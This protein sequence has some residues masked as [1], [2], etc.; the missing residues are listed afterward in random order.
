MSN[1]DLEKYIQTAKA[2]G[3]LDDAIKA[4]LINAGWDK[5]EVEKAFSPA[6]ADPNLPPPPTPHFGMWVAFLY[7]VL[8]ICLY[9]SFTGLG[10]VLHHL[11]DQTFPDNLDRNSYNYL[12]S[13]QDFFLKGYIAAIIVGFPIFAVLFLLLKKQALEKPAV[14]NLRT[15]KILIYMTLVGT[16]LIMIGHLIG[17][18][19]NF[20][21][22]TN[23]TRSLGHLAVT[24]LVAGT[25][26]VYLLFE[27]KEDRKGSW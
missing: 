26:F 10:G 21:G 20:L 14:R 7:I 11:V 1:S 2:K 16:F 5:N 22:G 4:S 12:S 19:Y 13:T 8:F 17:T 9:I 6:A 24:F 15:R 23:T 27:V 3:S 25:V 18:I